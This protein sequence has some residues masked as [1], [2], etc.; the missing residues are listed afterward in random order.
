MSFGFGVL[1][2]S[3]SPSAL[4]SATPAS[5]WQGGFLPHPRRVRLLLP[6]ES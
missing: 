1:A 6:A 3:E 2:L 5:L 4:P